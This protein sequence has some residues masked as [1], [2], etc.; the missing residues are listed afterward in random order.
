MEIG[1][2]DNLQA[3]LDAMEKEAQARRERKRLEDDW[4]PRK[5]PARS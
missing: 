2:F 3:A 1:V 5:Q 4:T